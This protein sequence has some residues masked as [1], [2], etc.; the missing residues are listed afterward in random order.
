VVILIALYIILGIALLI[1]LILV[2]RVRL[3]INFDNDLCVYLRF[4]FF[5]YRIYP[6]KPKKANPKRKKSKK[7]KKSKAEASAKSDEPKKEDSVVTKLWAI[8]KTLLTTIERFLG[9]LHFKFVK[10]NAVVGCENAAST[11]LLYGA[12]SQ[13]VAYLIEIL[14]NISNVDIS[15]R[16]EIS[17]KSDFVSQKSSLDGKIILYI[18]IAHLLYVLVDFLKKML[19]SKMKIG[20]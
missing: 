12:V 18:S 9:K 16:S 2:L 13:G 19:K 10:L 8:R 15:K 17:V 5:K 3:V 20:E 7:S 11:A 1:G 14:D 4:L 6:E